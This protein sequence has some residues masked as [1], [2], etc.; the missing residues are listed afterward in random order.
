VPAEDYSFKT[1]DGMIAGIAALMQPATVLDIGAGSGKYG[2]M[3]RSVVPDS[4]VIAVEVDAESINDHNLHAVYDQIIELEA[5]RLITEM[6]TLSVELAVLGDVIEHL[7]KS[8]GIDLLNWLHYRTSF[9]VIVTPEHMPMSRSPWYTGHNSWWSHRDFTWHD[10]WAS[11]RALQMQLFI[12]RGLGPAKVTLNQIV[13]AVNAKSM[14][15]VETDDLVTAPIEL[16]RSVES[17]TTDVGN[18]FR[19]RPD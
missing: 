12:L 1:Y 14:T 17:R 10:N 5:G 2:R 4:K 6:P 8:A 19:W 7:P 15:V 9:T 16:H 3:L 18:T 13:D 11:H